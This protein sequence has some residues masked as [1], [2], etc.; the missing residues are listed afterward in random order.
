V[1]YQKKALN[2]LSTYIFA[3]HAFD[4]D[5]YIFPFLQPQRRG[6]DFFGYTE[7]P[8]PEQNVL[9]LQINV[10]NYI[11]Y[12]TTMQR[13]NSTTLYG[14]TYS[15]ADVLKDLNAMLFEEDLKTD[16]NLYRQNIQT[17]FVK[18]AILLLSDPRYD[19][20]SKA[21]AYNTLT[22]LKDKLKK[23]SS[24]NEQTKA[25]RANLVYLIDKALVIK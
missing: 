4:A 11:M 1:D 7:N 17:E 16:V 25:H 18:K 15:S 9:F 3:P 13:L 6:F 19:N 10:L 14:N 20:A 22:E 24:S 21:A 8:K 23:A 12:P 2:T 5:T